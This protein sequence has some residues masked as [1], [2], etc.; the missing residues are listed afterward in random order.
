MIQSVNYSNKNIYIF[1]GPPGSGKGSLSQVCVRKLGWTQLSTGNLCR[2][3]IATQTAIGHEIDFSIRNG[4]LISDALM[5]AMVKEWLAENI[6][7]VSNLILDGF[8]RTQSQAQALD[9]ILSH[10]EMSD[11]N[12]HL[13]EMVLADETVIDRLSSRLVCNNKDCQ[14]VYSK[15][16]PE[17][18]P[19]NTG[20]CD[21]CNQ[22][23]VRRQ[24]DDYKAIQDRLIIYHAHTKELIDYYKLTD[25]RVQ[26]LNAE[27]PL[28]G[29]FE[30]F[31]SLIGSVAT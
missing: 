1:I 4:K 7:T 16:S 22:Q 6:N 25:R 19:K 27:K 21:K 18:A 15:S 24:D 2:H 5:C 12:L 30:D 29:V 13:V 17:L 23:L 11:F 20:I 26:L 3:H 8:P 9:D 10:V 14:A 28:D 31:L